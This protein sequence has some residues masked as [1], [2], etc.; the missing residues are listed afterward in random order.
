MMAFVYMQMANVFVRIWKFCKWVRG[1]PLFALMLGTVKYIYNFCVSIQQKAEEER[2]KKLKEEK[3][4][5]ALW[6]SSSRLFKTIGDRLAE[7]EKRGVFDNQA[8]ETKEEG[9][10]KEESVVAPC[11]HCGQQ[12]HEVGVCQLKYESLRR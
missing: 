11:P 5:N 3:E 1:W 7:A 2:K 4:S 8:E 9:L 12:G 6:K 10:K